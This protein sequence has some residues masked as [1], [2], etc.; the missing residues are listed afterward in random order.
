[1][2]STGAMKTIVQCDFDGTVTEKDMS[3]I[4]LDAF[5]DGNWRQ[6]LEDY[7]G[8]KISVGTFNTRAF[9]M[10]R[11]DKQ[12]LL[13][14]LFAHGEVKVRPGFR[15]LLTYCFERGFKFVVVSNGL[16]FYIEAI[17]RDIGADNIEVFAAQNKFRPEGVEV[18]YIGPDGSRLEDSFKESYTRSFLR[19]GYRVVYVGNGASDFPPARQAHH[20]FAIDDLLASCEETNLN[21]TPFNDLNDVVRGLELLPP[22]Q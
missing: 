8:G 15:E 1:M 20:V 7:R 12:T 19:D 10:V 22:G 17:L 21:C 13:D 3:F 9:A 6:I 11:A 5:A 14:F 16:I 2:H 4:L 18:R